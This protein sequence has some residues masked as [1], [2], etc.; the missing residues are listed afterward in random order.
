MN[1]DLNL[2]SVQNLYIHTVFVC[3]DIEI[4]IWLSLQVAF[5][6][7]AQFC[8]METGTKII[9]VILSDFLHFFCAMWEVLKLDFPDL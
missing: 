7:C 1:E 3:I 4:V 2:P 6:F 9:V 8:T 5:V